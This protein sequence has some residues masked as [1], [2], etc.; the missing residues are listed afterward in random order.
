MDSY[1]FKD[2]LHSEDTFG[3]LSFTS[4]GRV[5]SK[6]LPNKVNVTFLSGFK[7]R[8]FPFDLKRSSTF[9]FFEA[10]WQ[11]EDLYRGSRG[12]RDNV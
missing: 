5:A 10:E 2:V 9:S 1:L 11:E 3:D 7:Q 4:S 12:G 6:W 8:F